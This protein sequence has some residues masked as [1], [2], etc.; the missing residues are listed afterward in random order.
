MTGSQRKQPLNIIFNELFENVEYMKLKNQN[1]SDIK[2][3]FRS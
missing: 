2:N 3:F 1:Q